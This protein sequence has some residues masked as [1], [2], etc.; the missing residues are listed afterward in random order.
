MTDTFAYG[1][2]DEWGLVTPTLVNGVT[3]PI[4]PMEIL[5]VGYDLHPSLTWDIQRLDTIGPKFDESDI[6]PIGRLQYNTMS[7]P[8][9]WHWT[10]HLRLTLVVLGYYLHHSIFLFLH[11]HD[12][13]DICISSWGMLYYSE[14]CTKS[15]DTNKEYTK[16]NKK[17]KSKTS[18]IH[19]RNTLEE[20]FIFICVWIMIIF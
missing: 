12:H 9:C 8:S 6:L 3:V 7:C 13:V 10:S 4:V 18:V 2:F 17:M 15:R 20:Y 5:Q 14:I 16:Q 11:F 19:N 1:E